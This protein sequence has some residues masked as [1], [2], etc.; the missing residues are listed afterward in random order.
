MLENAN[1]YSLGALGIVKKV[2]LEDSP[3]IIH[4]VTQ[5]GTELQFFQHEASAC[6][7]KH[8]RSLSLKQK[9]TLDVVLVSRDLA[10]TGFNKGCKQSLEKQVPKYCSQ[11]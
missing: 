8:P 1:I 9:V 11:G 4:G 2:V 5:P 3:T 6:S 7:T 10:N